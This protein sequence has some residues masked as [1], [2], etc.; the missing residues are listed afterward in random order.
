MWHILLKNE[1]LLSSQTSPYG[2]QDV[3]LPLHLCGGIGESQS[4]TGFT[5]E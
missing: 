3:E 4:E 1:Y 2:I 5:L